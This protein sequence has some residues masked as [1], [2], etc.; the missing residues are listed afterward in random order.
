[1]HELLLLL[2]RNR[3]QLAAELLRK[4]EV[5]VPDF[6]EVRIESSD[7]GDIQ[8]TEYRA[9][10]V[11]F[12][13]RAA[14]KVL[15]IIVEVQL[16]WDEDKKYT[17]PA[18]VANL[19]ARHRCPVCLLVVTVDDSVA[20]WAAKLIELGGGSRI[21][22]WVVGPSNTP[23]VTD[24]AQAEADLELAVLSA[25]EH[26]QNADIQLAARVAS[27]AIL[28]SAGIDAERFRMYLDLILSS[29]SEDARGVLGGHE[30]TRIQIR[31][32]FRTPPQGWRWRRYIAQ[33]VGTALWT[34]GRC[35]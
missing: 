20:R 2:F 27:V 4:L 18:Y 14:Q 17:W 34:A 24:L 30:F 11:L 35:D 16:Q 32:R 9:D 28:A 23:V 13:M 15:G 3:S 12:L 31:E 29:L 6:N 5:H 22:P 7:L 26:G 8:P 1:M 33:A 19:R 21:V 25:K 10:L